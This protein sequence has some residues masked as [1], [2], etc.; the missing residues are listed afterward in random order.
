MSLMVEPIREHVERAYGDLVNEFVNGNRESY[1]SAAAAHLA[2]W[3]YSRN[4]A[5]KLSAVIWNFHS[6]LA[7]RVGNYLERNYGPEKRPYFHE[8]MKNLLTGFH[9]HVPLHDGSS[10]SLTDMEF[11][12]YLDHL[13]AIA[14]KLP[15][16]FAMA[17][18]VIRESM[19]LLEKYPDISLFPRV[20]SLLRAIV[21]RRDWRALSDFRHS[22][23]A[24]YRAEDPLEYFN[25]LEETYRKY[26]GIVGLNSI[27]KRRARSA[28]AK[29]ILLAAHAALFG[30]PAPKNDLR[31]AKDLLR[32][33]VG[34]ARD[35]D[36]MRFFSKSPLSPLILS[37]AV[38]RGADYFH[39]ILEHYLVH[40]LSPGRVSRRF[41]SFIYLLGK[42]ELP[43]EYHDL[44]S[45][46]W[47]GVRYKK[48][49]VFGDAKERNVV[50][51]LSKGD[52][53]TQL[54][55][56]CDQP[57]CFYPPNEHAQRYAFRY[58]FDPNVGDKNRPIIPVFVTA[59]TGGQSGKMVRGRVT[60]FLDPVGGGIHVTSSP[61]GE[62]AVNHFIDAI[63]HFA[64]DLNSELG[65][66]LF[67]R[68]VV[69]G[70][71]SAR[72]RIPG[73]RDLYDDFVYSD[74][75]THYVRDAGV[76]PVY[77]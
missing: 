12:E 52:V 61:A 20:K 58:I 72:F 53:D 1:K 54:Q 19:L 51:S 23:G 36:R 70:K 56:L 13:D 25:A 69:G 66:K 3:G 50:F 7:S 28:T 45:V 65:Q 59:A 44:W 10:T 68:I 24:F 2:A 77:E 76:F 67:Q 6:N 30:G 49:F 55:A 16:N 17:D 63:K 31:A 47:R 62:I 21:R 73:V 26:Y 74:G 37:Y 71:G 9:Y 18:H 8:I 22:V 27:P 32:Y 64:R 34:D 39:P 29:A 14:K 42:K 4:R 57:S 48:T 11:R 35:I 41:P 40:K 15:S 38:H 43:G 60:V 33:I 75:D 5:E 46:L